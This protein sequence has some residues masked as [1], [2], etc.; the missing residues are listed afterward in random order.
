MN[1]YS[2]IFLTSLYMRLGFINMFLDFNYISM[3]LYSIVLFVETIL[4]GLLTVFI[5]IVPNNLK[6]LL[7]FRCLQFVPRFLLKNRGQ[8][9]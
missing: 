1:Y 3:A 8:K 6:F 7:P 4:P 9:I 2:Y 5:E